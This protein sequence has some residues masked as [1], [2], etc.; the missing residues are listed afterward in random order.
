VSNEEKGKSCLPDLRV[1]DLT[2]GGC[3][4]CGKILGDLG[5][6]VIKIEPPGG[7]PTRNIG[8]FYKDIPDPQK[9]LFWFAYN[10]NKRSITLDIETS[11][12]QQIFKRLAKT[13]DFVIE[14]FPPGF[15]DKLGIGYKVLSQL[16]PKIIMTAITPFGQTGPKA[17]YK[18]CDFTIWAASGG[19]YTTGDADRPPIWISFPQP[20]IHAGVE[21]CIGSL[22]AYFHR[23][24]TGEG[25]YVDVSEEDVFVWSTDQAR[26]QEYDMVG[27]ICTRSG[28]RLP[29]ATGV[30]R[31]Q[32]FPCKDGFVAFQ[33]YGGGLH[34]GVVSSQSLVQ[35]M[36]EEN[37]APDWMVNY[38]WENDFD[39]SRV[40]Q[41][42][43]DRVEREFHKFLM[44]K[45]KAELFEQ[46]LKRKII[47]VPVNTIEDL[48]QLEHLKVRNFWVDVEHDELNAKLPYCGFL[49]NN[50]SQSPGKIR[51]RAPL[52]GEHNLEIF[53][54]EL[55]F[56]REEL[57]VLKQSGAI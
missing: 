30:I 24:N 51:R 44:T 13:A 14:S 38:D 35:W 7:S 5:A 57:S 26:A 49:H 55:G 6:D 42:E 18:S 1:L 54:G 43:V 22:L 21:A 56:S 9:S 12:G 27:K 11:D 2:E 50:F 39:T 15:L 48:C 25:Q 10:T 45:T 3:N 47:L 20:S 4:I 28:I 23:V 33:V 8:P 40:S 31:N 53:E 17:N 19:L 29:M 16:N 34:N 36:L 46:S 32:I 52:I 37:M 41:E